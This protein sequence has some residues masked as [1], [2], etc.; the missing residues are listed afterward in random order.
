MIRQPDARAFC[1]ALTIVGTSAYLTIARSWQDPALLLYDLA[2]VPVVLAFMAR[3]LVDLVNR[4]RGA[5]WAVRAMLLLPLIVVPLGAQFGVWNASGHLAAV[6]IVIGGTMLES[7]PALLAAGVLALIPVLCL[8]VLVFDDPTHAR[9]LYAMV[10]A[11]VFVIAAW[12]LALRMHGAG[13]LSGRRSP[14]ST[15]P[16]APR[17][18][19]GPRAGRGAASRPRSRSPRPSA[20]PPR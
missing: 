19:R 4:P 12:A 13:G 5:A 8:R 10:A 11:A 18:A 1:W 2:A 20:G 17:S 3:A 14:P 9:S 16:S 7:R 15:A 6:L